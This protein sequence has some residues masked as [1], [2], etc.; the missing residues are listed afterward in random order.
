[1]T[2]FKVFKENVHGH[3]AVNFPFSFALR[4]DHRHIRHLKKFEYII[5]KNQAKIRS[6][7][8]TGRKEGIKE[9]ERE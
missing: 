4:N 9:G 5:D 7:T 6:K 1:M 2:K 3:T 8:K